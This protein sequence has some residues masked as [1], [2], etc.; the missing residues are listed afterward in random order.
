VENRR[1]MSDEGEVRSEVRRRTRQHFLI[2]APFTAE[3]LWSKR[4]RI[5]CLNLLHLKLAPNG[6]KGKCVGIIQHMFQVN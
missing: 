5:Y 3:W 2:K 6:M 1:R 4:K